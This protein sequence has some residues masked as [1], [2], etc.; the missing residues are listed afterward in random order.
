MA[1]RDRLIPLSRIKPTKVNTD[2][3][4]GYGKSPRERGL[5]VLLEAE[6][7]WMA[8]T[9]F[10]RERERN[11]RYLFGDQWGD[12]VKTECGWMREAEMLRREGNTPLKQNMIRRLVRNVVGFFRNQ[13]NEPVFTAR[14]REEQRYGEILTILHQKN[15][16]RGDM[17]ELRARGLEEYLVSGLVCE[18]KRYAW[19]NDE[20]DC[21]TELVSP[22]LLIL[23][24]NM[25]D[26][27]GSDCQFIGMIHDVDFGTLCQEFAHSGRDLDDLKKT[28]QCARDRYVFSTRFTEFGYSQLR[29]WDFFITDDP[30]R[31]RVIEVWRRESRPRYRCHDWNTG[32]VFKIETGDKEELVDKENME[33]IKEG[34]SLGM[35]QEEIPLIDCEWFVDSLWYYYFL[36]PLGDILD[37][38][39]TPYEHK[40]HPFVFKAYPFMDG[41]IHSFVSDVIDQQRMI[42]RLVTMYDMAIRSSAKGLMM[43]PKEAVPDNM[44]YQQFA[45]MATSFRGM[46]F[47]KSKNLQHLPQVIT[48]NSTNIGLTELLQ[49]QMKMMEDISG[50]HGALQGKTPVSGTSGTLYAQQTENATTSLVD[51]VMSFDSFIR[52]AAR[53]EIMNLLQFYDSRRITYITGKEMPDIDTPDRIFNVEYDISVHEEKRTAVFREKVNEQLMQIWQTGQISLEQMLETGSFDFADDLLQ[54]IEADRQE[55]AEQQA[56]QQQQMQEQGQGQQQ[57]QQTQQSPPIQYPS[58]QQ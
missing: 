29:D 47:Y 6:K 3:W 7:Y 12:L 51:V 54:S 30:S 55:Q 31:C 17:D 14:A 32:E 43:I 5:Q 34:L 28:Y 16:Q 44:S 23:D 24:C 4:E 50:V 48:S 45:E 37:E 2:E 8:M 20:L 21:V 33:R 15:M 9:K 56:K 19:L 26:P 53:K 41:E 46:V 36:S 25:Q 39:E 58:P 27:R 52:Q 42:N 1:K 18:K 35:P 49:L 22:S 57:Q 38:G 11:K 13:D 40:S 10:R